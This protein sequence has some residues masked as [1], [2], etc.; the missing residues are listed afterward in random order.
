[1]DDVLEEL[2]NKI[3]WVYMNDIIIFSTSLQEHIQ[4]L[5]KTSIF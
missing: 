2:Q 4:N 3:L 1:M 5:T